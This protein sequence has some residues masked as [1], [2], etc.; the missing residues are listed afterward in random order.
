MVSARYV[1]DLA[2]SVDPQFGGLARLFWVMVNA[3]HCESALPVKIEV[4]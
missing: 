4:I 2:I 3:P 1:K